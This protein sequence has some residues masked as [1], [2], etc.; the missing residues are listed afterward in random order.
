M[1]NNKRSRTEAISV[2]EERKKDQ[3]HKILS[4]L[5]LPQGLCPVLYQQTKISTNQDLKDQFTKYTNTCNPQANTAPNSKQ[6]TE[7]CSSCLTNAEQ[8][9]LNLLQLLSPCNM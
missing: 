7:P 6:P 2:Q 3:E 9:A 5:T 4:W 8:S 1:H